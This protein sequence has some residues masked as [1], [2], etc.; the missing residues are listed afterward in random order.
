MLTSK[1]RSYLR[2]LINSENSILQVGKE[3]FTPEVA[4]SIDEALEKRELVKINVLNNCDEDVKE[5]ANTAQGRTRSELVQVIG[6]KFV[7]YRKSKTNPK[8]ELPK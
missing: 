2:G 1:Q 7:L 8:I 5:I 4:K 3:G 6:R